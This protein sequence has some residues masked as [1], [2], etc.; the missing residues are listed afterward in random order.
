MFGIIYWPAMFFKKKVAMPASDSVPT[1]DARAHRR[2]F[3]VSPS[4]ALIFHRTLYTPHLQNLSMHIFVWWT[5]TCDHQIILDVWCDWPIYNIKHL[6]RHTCGFLLLKDIGRDHNEESKER[7]RFL[8]APPHTYT[9][10]WMFSLIIGWV[11]FYQI[12][13]D[14]LGGVDEHE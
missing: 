10:P 12:K 1:V 13:N 3:R 8:Y 9:I 6:C 11:L 14:F 5:P 7:C 2:R 4:A